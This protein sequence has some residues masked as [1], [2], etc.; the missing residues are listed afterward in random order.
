MHVCNRT[1]HGYTN[2]KLRQLEQTI[3]RTLLNFRLSGIL[4][5]LLQGLRYALRA[6]RQNPKVF[7]LFAVLSLALGLTRRETG[8][9]GSALADFDRSIKL[10]PRSAYAYYARGSLLGEL[11]RFDE[12][13]ADFD[14]AVKIDP[15]FALAYANRGLA[16]LRRGEDHLARD[17]F[18]LC[19]KLDPTLSKEIEARSAEAKNRRR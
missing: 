13:I 10:D 16:R 4:R 11:G 5:N 19:L 15:Q 3:E 18:R 6:L 14:R 1:I 7:N 12:A 2:Q 9:L 8:D 17:D